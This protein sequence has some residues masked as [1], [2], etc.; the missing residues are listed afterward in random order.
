MYIVSKNCLLPYIYACILMYMHTYNKFSFK[1]E[2]VN[3][4]WQVLNMYDCI[5]YQDQ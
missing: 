1:A 2:I 3:I 5:H 4:I